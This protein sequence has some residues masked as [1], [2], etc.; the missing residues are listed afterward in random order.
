MLKYKYVFQIKCAE[1]ILS[2]ST[3]KLLW[4]EVSK[5]LIAVLRNK[6]IVLFIVI[7]DTL[8]FPTGIVAIRYVLPVLWTTLYLHIARNSDVIKEYT[9][10]DS[11]GSS[12]DSTP[13]Y[14]LKLT[15]QGTEPDRGEVRGPIYKISYDNLTIILR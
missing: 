14:I 1:A 9:Q 10:T 6:F 3:R 15:H 4:F 13:R 11:V 12:K 8:S 7:F 5:M 2:N